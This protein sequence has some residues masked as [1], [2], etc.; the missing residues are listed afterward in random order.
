MSFLGQALNHP[1]QAFDDPKQRGEE[2]ETTTEPHGQIAEAGNPKGQSSLPPSMGNQRKDSSYKGIFPSPFIPASIRSCPR[3]Y[4]NSEPFANW[5]E[6]GSILEM[7]W[8][9]D[10][11]RCQAR[12]QTQR[13]IATSGKYCLGRDDDFLGNDPRKSG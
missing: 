11:K 8:D 5:D 10:A 4:H 2:P 7:E 3:R 13:W 9:S 1:T 12:C 6:N